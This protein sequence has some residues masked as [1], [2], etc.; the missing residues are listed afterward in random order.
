MD[1]GG[2]VKGDVGC[3]S[4]MGACNNNN[5]RWQQTLIN[6]TL[7]ENQF[8]TTDCEDCR[9]FVSNAQSATITPFRNLCN[10]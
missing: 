7:H 5:K 4:T 3:N 8:E 10:A 1:E 9:S 2:R 6:I